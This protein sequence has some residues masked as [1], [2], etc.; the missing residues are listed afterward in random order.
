[1]EGG[2]GVTNRKS[3]NKKLNLKKVSKMKSW[4]IWD[5]RLSPNM[6]IFRSACCR[7]YG[8]HLKSLLGDHATVECDVHAASN[9][10]QYGVCLQ[11]S[12]GDGRAPTNCNRSRRAGG[13]MMM[14]WDCRRH[15]PWAPAVNTMV[16]TNFYGCLREGC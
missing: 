12:L 10:K 3:M 6:I 16:T 2:L 11:P 7:Q 14:G 13:P 4:Y 1:V 15:L 5:A 8:V 9:M